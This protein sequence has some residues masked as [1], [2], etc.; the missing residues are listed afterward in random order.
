M[1]A[2]RAFASCCLTAVT[3]LALAGTGRAETWRGQT[4]APEERCSACE[5]KRDYRYPPSIEREIVRRRGA[6]PGRNRRR[7][8]ARV[9][10]VRRDYRLAIDRLEADALERILSGC[11]SPAMKPLVCH[12]NAVQDRGT[13]TPA[14]VAI[15]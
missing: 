6:A 7:F 5:R 15:P 3:A 4:V 13:G 9:V 10:E 12:T 2:G 14:P 1:I 8:A 11:E